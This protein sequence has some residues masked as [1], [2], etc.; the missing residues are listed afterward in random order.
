VSLKRPVTIAQ[1][2][3]WP[4][5][6]QRRRS[7]C[8]RMGG[9]REQLTSERVARDPRSKINRALAA[10]DCDVPELLE[11]RHVTKG[12]RPMKITTKMVGAE[13]RNPAGRARNGWRI[14]IYDENDSPIESTFDTE[15]QG[16]LLYAKGK[17]DANKAGEILRVTSKAQKLA[18]WFDGSGIHPAGSYGDRP[19]YQTRRAML[20][21]NPARKTAKPKRNPGDATM[22]RAGGPSPIFKFALIP[23]D[24]GFAYGLDERTPVLVVFGT[25]DRQKGIYRSFAIPA[26]AVKNPEFQSWVR[27]QKANSAILSLSQLRAIVRGFMA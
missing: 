15:E 18:Y 24:G 9:M 20:R 1:A 19:I 5:A 27:S 7:F 26:A 8:A 6:A 11:G 17:A 25:R 3:Q 12:I 13:A 23:D 4:A 2:R 21:G 10:W 14:T 16:A 22:R